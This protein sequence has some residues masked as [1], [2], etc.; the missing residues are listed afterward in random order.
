MEVQP[1]GAEIVDGMERAGQYGVQV[2]DEVVTLVTLPPG[3]FAKIQDRTGWRFMKILMDPLERADVVADLVD[4]AYV[5]AG[6]PAPDFEDLSA[7][8]R[9]LVEVPGD[10]PDA[11]TVAGEVVEDPT[12]AT[13]TAG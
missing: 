1:I 9:L 4:A 7:Y 5:K 11:L 10:L 12:N 8:L 2:D 3:V 13:S 6:K